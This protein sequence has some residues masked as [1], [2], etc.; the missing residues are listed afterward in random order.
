MDKRFVLRIWLALAMFFHVTTQA[1]AQ[2]AY[3]VLSNDKK[4]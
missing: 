4:T 1:Y 3:Y 2:E